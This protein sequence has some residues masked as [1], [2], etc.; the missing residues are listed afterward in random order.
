MGGTALTLGRASEDRHDPDVLAT[1]RHFAAKD[2]PDGAAAKWVLSDD[3]HVVHAAGLL[4]PP[5][6]AVLSLKRLHRDLTDAVLLDVIARRRPGLIVLI[7]HV[8]PAE[9]VAHLTAGYRIILNERDGRLRVFECAPGAD[10]GAAR[11]DR[12]STKTSPGTHPGA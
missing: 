12:P 6:T 4:V 10:F 8:W 5:E 3:P 1:L 11:P 9:T 7:R 2:G